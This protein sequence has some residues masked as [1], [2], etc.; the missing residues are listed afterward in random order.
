MNMN[1]KP[2]TSASFTQFL[3][4]KRLMGSKCLSCGALCLPP[5]PLC[6]QCQGGQMEWVEF[7]GRGKLLGYACIAV[8]LSRMIE[9]G[10]SR[11][12]L[13]C[14]GV[15]ELDEGPKISARILGVNTQ[16]PEEIK[17]GA[18]LQ[19]EFVDRGEQTFLGFKPI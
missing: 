10:Y 3:K 5:R 13:Y 9:E 14:S 19:V 1:Q 6:T 17:I 15:V 12:R 4:E 18:P 8:G 7:K 11:E 2:F 16:K